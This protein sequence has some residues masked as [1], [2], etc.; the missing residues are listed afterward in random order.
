MTIAAA[1]ASSP[2]V[3]SS[4]NII[5]GLATSSTAMVNLLRCSV[6]S[7]FTPGNPTNAPLNGVSS[8]SSIIS[9]INIYGQKI[10]TLNQPQQAIE[11]ML[12][13]PK[14]RKLSHK[15]NGYHFVHN[16]LKLE[17]RFPVS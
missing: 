16:I 12:N 15:G 8:T 2:D 4:M 7:P 11:A 1:L 3:G 5:A 13:I 6:D 14:T 9:S 17:Q 10:N